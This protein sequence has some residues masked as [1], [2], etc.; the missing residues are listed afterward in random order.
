MDEYLDSLIQEASDFT[1]LCDF[2]ALET[3]YIGGGT[4]SLLS[5]KQFRYLW[6]SLCALMPLEAAVEKTIEANPES[7]TPEKTALYRELGFNRVSLGVQ[8]LSDETLAFLGRIHSASQALKAAAMVNQAG[9]KLNVDVIYGIPGEPPPDMPEVL[10]LNP[11]SISCYALA[12][13]GDSFKGRAALSDEEVFEQYMNICRYLKKAGFR[14][15]EV[16][17]WAIPG[18][19]CL[20]NMNYWKRKNYLGLGE[21]AASLIDPIRFV[22]YPDGY[23]VEKLSDSQVELEEIYL[24]LRTDEGVSAEM[25]ENNQ[26]LDDYRRLGLVRTDNGRLICTEKG[27]FVLD[28]IVNGLTAE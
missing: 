18:N 23:E 2:A 21:S 14:H 7:L 20:H 5:E 26:Q 25:I 15:Y 27:M 6:E 3:V 10:K 1:S 22:S 4:P 12:F 13:A 24:G 19:E 16:S 17:N 8:S 11:D 28:A 9:L